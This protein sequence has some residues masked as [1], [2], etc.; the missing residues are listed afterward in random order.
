MSRKKRSRKSRKWIQ[1]SGIRRRGHKGALHRA[2]G[3]PAG[4]IIPVGLL[5][6]A[7]KAAGKLGREARLAL[8]LK[9]LGR[10]RHKR[11]KHTRRSR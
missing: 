6:K 7:A 11:V 1:K 10:H 4:E 9:K 5:K 3:I 8:T 2:L